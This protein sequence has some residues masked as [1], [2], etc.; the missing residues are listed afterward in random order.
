MM[1]S[2]T[3]V[4]RR[5]EAGHGE[6]VAIRCAGEEITYAQ[7]HGRICAAGTFLNELG[8]GREDRVLMVLDD[9]PTFPTLFL[10]AMRI[11]AV[12]APVSFL[13]TTENFAHYARDSYAKLIVAEDH[14]LERLPAGAMSRTA[15]EEHLR[16][17]EGLTD[18]ADVHPDDM[19]FWLFSGGSTGFP[20]GVVHLHHDIPYTCETFAK[21]IL[22]ISQQDVTFSSTKLYHAYGLGNNLTFPYWVGATT[23][24][25]M[26]KPDPRG[27]LETAQAN[28]PSLFFS[29]PTL[30]G[31]M[32]NLPDAAD[33]DLSSVRFCVSAAEPLAPEVYRRW[34]AAFDLDIVDGIGSTEMLHIY[35]SNRPGAVKPGT[36][37][38]PVPG[39]ELVL[40]DELGQPVPQGEV[41]NLYVRGDS[42]LAYYWHQHEKTKAAIKGDLF[43][44]GDRY[45]E[46]AD[47][48]YVY[49][50]RADDMIKIGGLWASP[51]EI[52][53]ALVEHPRVL[54]A[55]AVGVDADYTT[56][57]KAFV[58]VRGESG[59]ESLVLE[60]QE[61]CKTRLR[62]YEFPHFI[63][64][65]DELP[66]TPTGKIQRYK[67][68]EEA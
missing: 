48:D 37:G 23:V 57:V 68:R 36:S 22:E 9:T 34:K 53:N 44:T 43:F 50:G 32:V 31:A 59:D 26:G 61:W 16:K 41:G 40:L 35:C 42:A 21:E 66:K 11:G 17:H 62:R 3:L 27:L 33:Y 29:V 63:A 4:D 5:L 6:K 58:I 46:D 38:K 55:A 28:Q 12:P 7:L 20:K 49:E 18:P 64:F 54:E 45:R 8:I 14:L 19:A 30:Y 15:F 13:D 56:R 47:G 60:L 67:L 24:L 51:I 39:Y 10:G 1:N 25:R 65:V 52:E 2:G